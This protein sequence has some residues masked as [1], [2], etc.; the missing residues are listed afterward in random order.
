MT[1]P[2]GPQPPQ[3]PNPPQP[4]QHNRQEL[5]PPSAGEVVAVPIAAPPERPAQR[6]VD[7]PGVQ[8]RLDELIRDVG[9]EPGTFHATLV[10]DL[11][12]AGLKLIPDGRDTGELKL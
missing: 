4:A 6:R 12:S 1:T 5:D 2:T 11:L 7:D 8:K 9:G 10:R 3:P